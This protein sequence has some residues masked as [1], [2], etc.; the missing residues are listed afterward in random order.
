MRIRPKKTGYRLTSIQVRD[1]E[2]LLLMEGFVLDAFNFIRVK[3]TKEGHPRYNGKPLPLGR[4]DKENIVYLNQKTTFP[5]DYIGRLK[6]IY[7]KVI[8]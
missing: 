4:I 3:E 1:L 6:R 8:Q 7:K 5:D 2:E